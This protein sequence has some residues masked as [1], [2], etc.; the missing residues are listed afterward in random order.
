MNLPTLVVS[1][2]V[3]G[4]QVS[5]AASPEDLLNKCLP[6]IRQELHS[7]TTLPMVRVSSCS[8]GKDQAVCQ[9]YASSKD[10]M[11]TD[12]FVFGLKDDC[13]LSFYRV[14]AQ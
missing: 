6:T 8:D 11:T 10:A 14:T 3:F 7:K 1:L 2:I 12:D 9:G 5:F 13:K 4:T